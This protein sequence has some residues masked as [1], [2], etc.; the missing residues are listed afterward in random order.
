LNLDRFALAG[1]SMGGAVAQQVALNARDKVVA[2]VLGATGARLPVSE[3]VFQAIDTNF[4]A[5]GTL[6]GTFAFSPKTDRALVR[7][8][9]EPPLLA[10]QHTVRADFEACARFDVRDQLALLDVPTLVLWGEDDQMVSGRRVESLARRIP[11]AQF[12]K[13]PDV[14]HMLFQEAPQVVNPLIDEFLDRAAP[15]GEVR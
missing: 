3:M 4:D 12:E 14:G 9:T 2:L 1:H 7:K 13:I 6:L 11:G 8:W 5:F 10:G 15:T